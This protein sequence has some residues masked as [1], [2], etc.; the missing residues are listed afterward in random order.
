V[1]WAVGI[2]AFF[3]ISRRVRLQLESE[4]TVVPLMRHALRRRL[5]TAADE[6]SR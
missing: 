3:R 5:R 2:T 1:V 4:G 6:S